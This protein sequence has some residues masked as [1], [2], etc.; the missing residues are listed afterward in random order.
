[1][2]KCDICGK[3][4]FSNCEFQ[5]HKNVHT[6]DKPYMCDICGK[7]YRYKNS[8]MKHKRTHEPDAKPTEKGRE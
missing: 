8:L 5:E 6:G 7:S 1:M 4:F 2:L 3:G